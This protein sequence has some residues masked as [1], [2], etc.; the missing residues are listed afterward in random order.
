MIIYRIGADM[1]DELIVLCG[2]FLNNIIPSMEKGEIPLT[3]GIVHSFLTLMKTIYE[4]VSYEGEQDENKFSELIQMYFSSENYLSVVD[5]MSAFLR[6]A[7]CLLEIQDKLNYSKM[8]EYT[9]QTKMGHLLNQDRIKF[10]EMEHSFDEAERFAGR[11]VVYSAI[12]GDYDTLEEDFA[13]N[14]DFDHLLFTNNKNLMS[15]KWKVVFVENNVGL[16]VFG[17]AC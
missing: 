16:D 1:I 6:T 15:D 9:T 14:A 8:K 10:W 12:T 7:L 13:I 4:N 3:E 11:G 5:T 17:V 2:K